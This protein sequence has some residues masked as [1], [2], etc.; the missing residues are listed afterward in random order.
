MTTTPTAKWGIWAIPTESWCYDSIPSEPCLY[1]TRREA[2]K[3][4]DEMTMPHT[5][6]HYE[7]RKYTYTGG[8]ETPR[9]YDDD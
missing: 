2:K 4:M 3:E 1:D 8:E 6:A 7:V 5:K 9:C